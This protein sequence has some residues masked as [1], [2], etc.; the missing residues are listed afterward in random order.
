[1][2]IDAVFSASSWFS[3]TSIIKLHSVKEILIVCT[4]TS[5]EIFSDNKYGITGNICEPVAPLTMP[6][7]KPTIGLSRGIKRLGIWNCLLSQPQQPYIS[8]TNASIVTDCELSLCL[9]SCKPI[10]MP[11]MVISSISQKVWRLMRTLPAS[12]MT[13]ILDINDGKITIEM[14]VLRSMTLTKMAKQIVEKPKPKEPLINAEKI[15]AKRMNSEVGSSIL[16]F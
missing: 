9:K 8:S 13:I 10:N 6:V 5:L 1:M 11:G 12:N 16:L 2:K 14:A 4:K 3:D 7:N 15:S